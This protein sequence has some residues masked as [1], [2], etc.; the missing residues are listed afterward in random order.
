MLTFVWN[1]HRFQVVDADSIRKFFTEIVARRGERG[2]RKLVAHA[3]NAR[4]HTAR[5]TRAF[6]DENFLRIASHSHP[7]YSPDLAP[8]D[9]S[10]FGISETAFK[11]SN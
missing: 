9:F 11:D 8:S 10:Y 2:E 3:G 1:L 5:V 7:P 6:G 4:P